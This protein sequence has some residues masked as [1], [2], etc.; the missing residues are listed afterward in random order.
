MAQARIRVGITASQ[1]GVWRRRGRLRDRCDAER[2]AGSEGRAHV[3]WIRT[4]VSGVPIPGNGPGLWYA[5]EHADG[6]WTSELVLASDDG[7]YDPGLAVAPDGSVHIAVARFDTG[8]EGVWH[9]S[10]ETGPWVATRV[11]TLPAEA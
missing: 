5:V 2:R 10:D 3:A 4:P 7:L 6:T 1:R 8:N 9:L 11:A